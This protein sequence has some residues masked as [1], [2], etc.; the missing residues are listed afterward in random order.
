MQ[1]CY[2]I[3]LLFNAFLGWLTITL[4]VNLLFYKEK[5][6]KKAMALAALRELGDNPIL[7][8]MEEL[9]LEKEL[10][11]IIDKRLDNLL[12]SYRQDMPMLALFMTP[13]LS[14][15]IKGKGKVEILK[16]L[17][18]IKESLLSKV[19]T[20]FNLNQIVEDKVAD[21]QLKPFIQQNFKQELLKLKLFSATIALGVGLVEIAALYLFC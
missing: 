17:P 16:A 19:K 20:E 1:S 10:E 18:D 2:F 3:V 13:E 6:L 12:E 7:T 11:P 9:D 4:L 14:Q 21:F 15:S 5:E 8:K